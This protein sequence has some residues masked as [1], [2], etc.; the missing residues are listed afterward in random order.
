MSPGLRNWN[1]GLLDINLEQ[2]S[3]LAPLNLKLGLL[4]SNPGLLDFST[5]GLD[6]NP[7]LLDWTRTGSF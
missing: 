2:D 7:G 5:G 1:P 4:N 3:S 6:S